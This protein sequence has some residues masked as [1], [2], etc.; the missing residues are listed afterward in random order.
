MH[1]A[2]D[3]GCLHRASVQG[4]TWPRYLILFTVTQ[5]SMPPL[6]HPALGL[7]TPCLLLSQFLSI[8]Q[9][10]SALSNLTEQEG[11]DIGR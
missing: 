1:R 11:R 10:F 4:C 9:L 8:S 6:P 3:L 5:R 7:P 2:S